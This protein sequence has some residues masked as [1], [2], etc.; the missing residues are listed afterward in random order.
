MKIELNINDCDFYTYV[1]CL[2]SVCEHPEAEEYNMNDVE[3]LAENREGGIWIH[4]SYIE[5]EINNK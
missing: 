5:E 2:G 4:C 3:P 1:R